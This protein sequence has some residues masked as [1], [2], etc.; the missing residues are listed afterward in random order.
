MC[1]RISVKSTIFLLLD[2]LMVF[3]VVTVFLTLFLMTL[4]NFE[5]SG[6]IFHMILF[7]AVCL[8]FLNNLTRIMGLGEKEQS[9]IPL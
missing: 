3:L 6:L 2:L 4:I 1:S 5:D 9:E 7:I 8:I